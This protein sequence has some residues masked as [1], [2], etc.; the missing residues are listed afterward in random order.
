MNTRAV[1]LVALASSLL[2]LTCGCM[3]RVY[4]VQPDPEADIA[5]C[6]R[7]VDRTIRQ[8]SSQWVGPTAVFIGANENGF[9]VIECT[10]GKPGV[11][12]ELYGRPVSY[13]WD[14]VAEVSVRAQITLLFL[15][16]MDPTLDSSVLVTLRDGRKTNIKLQGEPFPEG[17]LGCF[18]LWPFSPKWSRADR[19]G[20]AIQAVVGSKSE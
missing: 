11:G 5:D 17:C 12:G 4:R 1:L 8:N 7:L 15:I 20:K 2:G 19:L 6:L 18:P 10:S 9:T 14:D 16:F 13:R 3:T